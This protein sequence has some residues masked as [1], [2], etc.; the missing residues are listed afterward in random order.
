V[1][2]DLEAELEGKVGKKCER[3]EG[4]HG[5]VVGRGKRDCACDTY[6]DASIRLEIGISEFFSREMKFS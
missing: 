6:T 5:G 2:P 3:L 4:R 1:L